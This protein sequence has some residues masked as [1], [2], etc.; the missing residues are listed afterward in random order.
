MKTHA[1]IIAIAALLFLCTL[2][3]GLSLSK[4]LK[5]SDPRFSGRPLAGALAAV[6]KAAACLPLSLS[7][8]RLLAALATLITLALII[9]NLHRSMD[10]GGVEWTVV[11]TTGFLFLLM[12]VTGTLL[13]LGK[14]ATEVVQVAHK[15]GAF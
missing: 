15:V 1:S 6:H 10:C 13:S 2:I 4:N 14:A 5:Q 3:F 12:F 9:R 8:G 11:I 7:S